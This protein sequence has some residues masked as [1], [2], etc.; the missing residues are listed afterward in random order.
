MEDL[1][2]TID[3]YKERLIETDQ[4]I[5]PKT[6][7]DLKNLNGM[8]SR[9]CV[10]I[11]KEKRIG[12]QQRSSGRPLAMD[13]I[14]EKFL[15]HCTE[16]KS[17]AHGRR[18]DPVMYLHHRVKKKDFLNLV[19]HNRITRGLSLV[20]S[21]FTS[22]NRAKPKNVRSIQAQNNKGLGLFCSKKP[23]K[24]EEKENELFHH[25]RAHTKNILLSLCDPKKADDHKYNLLI[26]QDDK[27]YLCP[28]T[29]T[30][31]RKEYL[32]PGTS[33]GMRSARNVTVFQSLNQET[34]KKLPK[35]DFPTSLLNVTPGVHRI[36]VKQVCGHRWK[37]RN[38]ID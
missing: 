26:S 33:T 5:N 30:G 6:S 4:L 1:N 29:S 8:I 16:N 25:Q 19:N 3:I 20:K 28:G 37:A 34:S 35:Y 27:A 10:Q 22:Y 17:T 23:P 11:I 24:A 32:C 7:T 36:M 13:E 38:K 31:M 18:Q 9:A 21:S 2:Q 14:D 12:L 15:L